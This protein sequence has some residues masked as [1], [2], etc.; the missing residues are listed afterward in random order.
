AP[1]GTALSLSEDDLLRAE[2]QPQVVEAE[3]GLVT[4]TGTWTAHASPA[5]SGGAYLYSSGGPED[6]LTLRFTGSA[7]TVRYVS[8]PALGAF[9]L[10]LDG[11]LRQPVDSQGT[12]AFDRRVTITGLDAG[13][14]QLQLVPL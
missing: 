8:H 7:V 14:H 4:A 5:A 13:T 11:A 3:S 9:E 10:R 2:P 6:T 1:G 12:Q